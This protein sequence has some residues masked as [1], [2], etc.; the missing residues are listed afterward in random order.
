MRSKKEI[1]YSEKTDEDEENALKEN[2]FTKFYAVRKQ[3]GL[4]RFS[5]GII[6]FERT[7]TTDSRLVKSL[8]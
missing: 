7:G 4:I 5:S 8:K 1:K 2:Y 3:L 6:N